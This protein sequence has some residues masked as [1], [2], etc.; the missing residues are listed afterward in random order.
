M[1]LPCEGRRVSTYGRRQEGR[2]SES[3]SASGTAKTRKLRD[4]RRT[5][6]WLRFQTESPAQ[7]LH[8][9]L[10]SKQP[11]TSCSARI[12]AAA[13]IGDLHS[14]TLLRL[15]HFHRR[16]PRAGVPHSIVQGRLDHAVDADLAGVGQIFRD[17]IRLHTD[18]H[19]TVARYFAP[20]PFE[21][22]LQ[23]EI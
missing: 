17:I 2:G 19:F 14:D 21:C 10:H 13:I 22:G 1:S 15:L 4:D 11:H 6:T 20:E 8:A 3:R 7:P 23:P 12:E 16:I 9:F 5:L 18:F